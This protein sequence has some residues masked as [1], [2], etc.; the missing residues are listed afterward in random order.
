VRLRGAW[1]EA[2][3]EARVAAEE[4]KEHG[5]LNIAA[6]AF[7]ELGE[8]RLRMGDL[9]SAEEAFHQAHELG[10]DPQPGL[11]LA[12]LAKGDV[13]AARSQIRRALAE[14]TAP[15]PR[16]KLLPAAVE[17]AIARGELQEAESAATELAQIADQYGTAMLRAFAATAA[18]ALL[19]ARGDSGAAEVRL[20]DGV[21]LWQEVEAPYEMAR[22]RE[23]LGHAYRAGG[24]ESAAALELAAARAVF[25]RLGAAGDLRRVSAALG[26]PPE[27]PRRVTRT[28]MFT[29]IAGST[30]L[31]ETLGDEAWDDLRQWHDHALRAAFVAHH[32]E[33]VD[34]TGDGFF[35][36]FPGASD[37]I[38]CAV[39][40]QRLLAEHRQTHGFAPRVRIGLHS[41]VATRASSSYQGLGVHAAARIGSLAGGDEVL[42]TEETLAAADGQTWPTLERREV[43][44][45]GISTPVRVA[46]IQ[47]R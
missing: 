13:G 19:L 33:E 28:F 14:L 1:T 6:F 24:D 9:T 17:I 46:S 35:V 31:I 32:G 43:S 42:V 20:R 25:E 22:T 23:L 40:I 7:K 45:K 27:A 2:E 4:L 29:D 10:V 16:A 18:G 3:R 38:E 30:N 39:G 8:I 37:A 21:R 12:Q 11:A 47:W 34:Q 44:L 26:R 41:D 5:T 15:L 36:A